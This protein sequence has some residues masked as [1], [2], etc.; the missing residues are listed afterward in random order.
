MR[1]IFRWIGERI[2][3]AFMLVCYLMEVIVLAI[4][5]TLMVIGAVAIIRFI[6]ILV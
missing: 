3:L 4:I 1:K 2:W 6:I 5:G